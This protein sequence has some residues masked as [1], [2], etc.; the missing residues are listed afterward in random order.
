MIQI[1]SRRGLAS[2]LII[3]LLVLLIF[4]GVLSLVTTAADYRLARKRADWN[5]AYYKADAAAVSVLA[6][7]DRQ[8][9]SLEPDSLQA[10]QL[11]ELLGNLLNGES[12]V[13][14]WQIRPLMDSAVQALTLD[15]LIVGDTSGGQGISLR[16]SI[17]TGQLQ[18]GQQRFSIESW[19]QW[20]PE[21]DYNNSEGG[22]W[23]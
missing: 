1:R 23:K 11:T 2:A 4:F 13:Q 6:R 9:A 18:P 8:I 20:Q 17:R 7:L 22:I 12:S 19:R 10:D 14:T 16:L 5:D 3:M 21:F 15:A